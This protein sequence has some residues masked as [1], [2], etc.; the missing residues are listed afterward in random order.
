MEAAELDGEEIISELIQPM[1][2][3]PELGTQVVIMPHSFLL[4]HP[5]AQSMQAVSRI[6]L[7]LLL[8]WSHRTR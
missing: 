8:T 5:L 2:R 6:H 3:K 4:Q 1:I 7:L